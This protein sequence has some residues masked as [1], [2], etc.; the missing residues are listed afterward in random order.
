[1]EDEQ[2]SQ[3]G[4]GS[5]NKLYLRIKEGAAG[6]EMLS[7]VISKGK[8]E[9]GLCF[10]KTSI[11]IILDLEYNIFIGLGGVLW[12]ICL[13]EKLLINGAFLKEE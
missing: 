12:N 1:M 7:A 13:Q 5:C 11:A 9:N 10:L 8:N 4:A 6:G 3:Q 2:H